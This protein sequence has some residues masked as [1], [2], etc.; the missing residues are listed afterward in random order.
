[1]HKRHIF[2]IVSGVRCCAQ[3]ADMEKYRQHSENLSRFCPK[4]RN[5]SDDDTDL[6]KYFFHSH[7]FN[8]ENVI[9]GSIYFT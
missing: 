8:Q 7:K 2:L 4:F 9:Q 1:M 6:A 5:E 3:F